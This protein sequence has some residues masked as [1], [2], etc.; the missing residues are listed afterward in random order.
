MKRKMTLFLGLLMLGSVSM[1][2]STDVISSMAQ[3]TVWAGLW[4]LVGLLCLV[5]M[6]FGDYAYLEYKRTGDKAPW[7]VQLFGMLRGDY[8]WVSGNTKDAVIEG[9]DYDGIE[10]FDNDLPTWWKMGFY[11][12][13]IFGFIYIGIYHVFNVGDLQTAEFDKE[14]VVA[15]EQYANV[16]L[17]YD[18]PTADEM[19]LDGIRPDFEKTCGTCHNKDGGGNSG[20]N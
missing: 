17:V 8:G 7:Y 11:I 19:E 9:H 2:Q 5:I 14:M 15:A 18:G 13:I 3:T 12:C 1:A 4:V 10:E 20:P 6:L 16:D